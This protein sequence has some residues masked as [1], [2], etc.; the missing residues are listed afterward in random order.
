MQTKQYYVLHAAQVLYGL[1]L[2]QPSQQQQAFFFDT[3]LGAAV[4]QH[5]NDTDAYD[6]AMIYILMN[7]DANQTKYVL[8]VY[9]VDRAMLVMTSLT[10]IACTSLGGLTS[11]R[12]DE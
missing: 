5:H 10:V 3:S 2:M 1:C 6:K 11:H 8:H 7:T 12:P 4:Q 9:H